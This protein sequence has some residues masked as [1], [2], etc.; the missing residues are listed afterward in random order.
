MNQKKYWKSDVELDTSNDFVS[1]L[2]HKEFVEKLPEDAFLGDQKV[3]DESKTN[4]R[5]FLKYVGFSTAAA[6]LAACEGPVYKSIP[7]VVQPEEIRPG[8]SNYY[9]STIAD[10]FDFSNVLIKT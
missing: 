4:R 8:I 10:G 2:Q 7:Y 5:D 3:M 6:S 1:D 9:A